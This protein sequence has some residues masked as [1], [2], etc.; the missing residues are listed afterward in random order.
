MSTPA[1]SGINKNVEYH[2]STTQGQGQEKTTDAM[3][4]KYGVTKASI[5]ESE[6]DPGQFQ[7]RTSVALDKT[8]RP[9]YYGEAE[10]AYPMHVLRRQNLVPLNDS[11]GHVTPFA[12]GERVFDEV[13]QKNCYMKL[14]PM[15]FP[16]KMYMGGGAE[17][18]NKL[19]A[20]GQGRNNGSEQHRQEVQE[21]TPKAD[22]LLENLDYSKKIASNHEYVENQVSETMNGISIE[23]TNMPTELAYGFNGY[24][25]TMQRDKFVPEPCIT[26]RESNVKRSYIGLF[27]GT[28]MGRDQSA[29]V[30]PIN[31]SALGSRGAQHA[32]ST[33]SRRSMIR[34]MER[35]APSNRT[36]AFSAIAGGAMGAAGIGGHGG[37][38]S[39]IELSGEEIIQGK[40]GGA[41]GAPGDHYRS[42]VYVSEYDGSMERQQGLGVGV[43]GSRTNS[44]WDLSET[45]ASGARQGGG[46]GVEGMREIRKNDFKGALKQDYASRT[47]GGIGV[48]SR[49][50]GRKF[51]LTSADSF[52]GGR[53]G[54]HNG[55]KGRAA[56]PIETSTRID[57]GEGRTG[58]AFGENKSYIPRS[59][60]NFTKRD[61]NLWVGAVGGQNDST[62]NRAQHYSKRKEANSRVKIDGAE[63]VTGPLPTAT[64]SSLAN[65]GRM[66]SLSD[67]RGVLMQSHDITVGGPGLSYN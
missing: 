38:R 41:V 65:D 24:Q 43:T 23:D 49:R 59:Q 12:V 25:Y 46:T 52:M 29:S 9:E 28:Q 33:S 37:G 39:K 11:S 13:T 27:Q 8:D 53:T 4:M 45:D 67:A 63:H 62:T 15:P 7:K 5:L 1:H 35:A 58:G 20:Q 18:N 54:T 31:K 44:A 51:E 36:D 50:T 64:P 3:M 17:S 14:D 47:G 10:Q 2:G 19:A 60:D 30:D 57:A 21:L 26:G 22:R 48:E 61:A 42:E 32:D 55:D 56:A 66:N 6:E 40:V 34:S 16:D